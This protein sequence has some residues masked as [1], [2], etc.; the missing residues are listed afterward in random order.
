MKE[1]EIRYSEAADGKVL[2]QWL[3][4]ETVNKW[5]PP[6]GEKEINLFAANWISFTKYSSSLTATLNNAICGIGTLFLMPYKKVS[7]Q[8]MLYMITDPESPKEAEIADNLL[9]NMLNLAKNY[10]HL[11][12]VIIEL[13]EGSSLT[14]ILTKYDFKEFGIQKKYVKEGGKYYNKILYQHFLK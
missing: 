12:M 1:L 9:K 11:E 8:C 14:S 5:F 6:T 4:D 7:H 3:N 13:F 10:F 2:L